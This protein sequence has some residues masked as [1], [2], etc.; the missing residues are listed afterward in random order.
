VWIVLAGVENRTRCVGVEVRSYDRTDERWNIKPFDDRDSFTPIDSALW[1]LLPIGALIE[2]TIDFRRKHYKTQADRARTG[3]PVQ[4][5]VGGPLVEVPVGPEA[6]ARA[7]EA[8]I[9]DEPDKPRRGPRRQLSL[10]DLATVVVPAY[11]EGGRRPVVAVRDALSKHK[12]QN[13][14]MEQARKAVVR[15]REAG[16]LPPAKGRGKP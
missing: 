2:R 1:R 6:A 7:I 16:L 12:R 4:W 11:D 9:A 15:A 5:S 10:E 3:E 8:M 14:T 13:I